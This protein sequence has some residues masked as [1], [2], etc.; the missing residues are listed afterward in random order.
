MSS[1]ELSFHFAHA[2]GFPA[3]SYNAMFSA[4]PDNFNRLHVERFGHDP[5]LPV[6]GNWRNQVQELIKHVKKENKDPRG[7][8]GVGHSFGAV[9]TYMA[10]CEAPELFR[11]IILFDPPLVVG[12]LSYFFRV[13]KHTPLINKLTPAKLAQTRKTRW[14]KSTDM[15]SYFHSKALFKDM[16]RRCVRDYVKSVTAVK[17]DAISLT[18]RADVEAALFQNI[19]HDLGKYKRKLKC[20]AILATGSKSRVCKP[21]MVS[22]L[23]KHNDIEHVVL[24]GGHMFPL[25]HP[26]RVAA[27]IKDTLTKWNC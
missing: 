22:R 17:G 15:E 4:L 2:N 14:P 10:A 23:I 12:P 8:F 27:F 1:T 11:G 9:I 13:A 21:E 19:P 3:G 20:P 25:E 16:D 18:F 24:D 6:N 26:E 5:T 7:V